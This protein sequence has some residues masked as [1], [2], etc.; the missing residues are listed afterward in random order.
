MVSNIT[1]L[2]EFASFLVWVTYGSC[3]TGLLILR[4]TQPNIPRPYRVPTIIPIFILLIAIFLALMPIISE[5]SLKYLAALGFIAIGMCLYTPFVYYK[6]RP[7]FMSKLSIQQQ[8][9]Q[10]KDR[11]LLRFLPFYSD[12]VTYILQ[13]LFNVASTAPTGS[14]TPVS[15]EEK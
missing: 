8:Q 6:K 10:Q 9:Q 15:T 1:A 4:K 7:R 14:Y 13:M 12:K 3:I 11:F 2:I 5:P